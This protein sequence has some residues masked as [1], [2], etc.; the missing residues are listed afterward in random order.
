MSDNEFNF[1]VDDWGTKTEKKTKPKINN[2]GSSELST[3]SN[4]TGNSGV[5]KKKDVEFR[6]VKDDIDLIKK[7]NLQLKS[8]IESLKTQI[9]SFNKNISIEF[10]IT[11]SELYRVVLNRNQNRLRSRHVRE[12]TQFPDGAVAQDINLMDEIAKIFDL[13]K[14]Q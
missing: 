9:N 4:P 10:D 6:Q 13:R 3:G 1:N 2:D 12:I 14:P 5:N 11:K 7:E 8:E